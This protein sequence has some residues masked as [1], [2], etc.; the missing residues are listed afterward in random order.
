M[1][2]VERRPGDLAASMDGNKKTDELEQFLTFIVDQE[3]Y[4]VDILRVQEIRV[5]VNPWPFRTP[6]RL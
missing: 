1:M 6:P 4:G 2:G 3:E 5:G